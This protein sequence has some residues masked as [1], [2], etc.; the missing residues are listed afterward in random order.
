MRVQKDYIEREL[1]EFE[2][3]Y[4]LHEIFQIAIDAI[5]ERIAD[6]DDFSPETLLAYRQLEEIRTLYEM[7]QED[8]MSQSLTT[9]W[10]SDIWAR[11]RELTERIEASDDLSEYSDEIRALI[12][13]ELWRLEDTFRAWTFRD[14]VEWSIDFKWWGLR[15]TYN[16]TTEM[17]I[18]LDAFTIEYINFLEWEAWTRID[19]NDVPDTL[20]LSETWLHLVLAATL[21][22][23]HAR[24]RENYEEVLQFQVWFSLLSWGEIVG[25]LSDF[26]FQTEQTEEDVQSP[27]VAVVTPVPEIEP[28]AD[29]VLSPEIPEWDM[30]YTQVIELYNEWGLEIE[31]VYR[32]LEWE[33]WF[34][35]GRNDGYSLWD[36]LQEFWFSQWL[37]RDIDTILGRELTQQEC[38]NLN[39]MLRYFL[40]VESSGWY[41]VANYVW[42][43]TAKWYFQYLTWDGGYLRENLVAWE[44]QRAGRWQDWVQETQTVRRIWWNNS[45][46]T[47]LSRIPE[48]VRSLRPI[49]VE[50]IVKRENPSIQ[51]PRVL[52][53]EEQ[54]ILFL[55]DLRERPGAWELIPRM[56]SGEIEAVEEL[57]RLHHTAPDRATE[58]RMLL[59]KRDIYNVEIEVFTSF[60]NGARV[61]WLVLPE[62]NITEFFYNL[63]HNF[64]SGSRLSQDD[65]MQ[66]LTLLWRVSFNA[67]AIIQISRSSEEGIAYIL[68]L[69]GRDY[70][71]VDNDGNFIYLL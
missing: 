22:R 10:N 62:V 65:I 2:Q 59:A 53:V 24:N 39:N 30:N 26:T 42:A 41:N 14:K 3:E 63:I 71:K 27:Q 47:G 60:D 31:E 4:D 44:W 52:S 55:S 50:E 11:F 6:A 66:Q 43:S 56:L 36:A 49:F 51:D 33:D 25:N 46:E 28:E 1:S 45:Y 70:M 35:E 5:Q 13:W 69:N 38:L 8:Y 23:I 67:W 57:Y 7:F 17:T 21:E 12:D 61:E 29:V 20:M 37:R 16:E 68:H 64:N 18:F 9:T 34:Q 40:Y 54:I 19:Y 58:L 32:I 48:W 15:E